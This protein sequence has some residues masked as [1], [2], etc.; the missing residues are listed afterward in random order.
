MVI[1]KR[2]LCGHGRVAVGLPGLQ[3]R[4]NLGR[5]GRS[6]HPAQLTSTVAGLFFHRDRPFTEDKHRPD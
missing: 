3:G 2:Y 6:R 1:I 5:L 4:N